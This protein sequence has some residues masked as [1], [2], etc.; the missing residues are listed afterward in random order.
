VVAACSSCNLV[1]GNRM[2]RD[3]GMQ[4][5]TE[6]HQPT[7]FDLQENGRSFPPNFQHESWRDFLYWDTE[8]DPW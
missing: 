7:A 6:P 5:L 8:L 3:C 2:P 1:K 4:P